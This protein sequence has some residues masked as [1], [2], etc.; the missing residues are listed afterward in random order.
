MPFSDREKQREYKAQWARQRRVSSAG[1]SASKAI[2][3]EV[4]IKTAQ[5]IRD[6]LSQALYAVQAD[7]KAGT[8]EKARVIGYLAGVALK[9]VEASDLEAR[10][11]TLEKNEQ[12][13]SKS[14][15]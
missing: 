14:R 3:P 15:G 1:S 11:E 2:I 5:E 10:I 9:A 4:R 7:E 12:A 8:L 13:R 6:L